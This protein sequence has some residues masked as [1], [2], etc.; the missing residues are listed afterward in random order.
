MVD[1]AMDHGDLST[2]SGILERRGRFGH[3]EHLELAWSFLASYPLEDA[4][5]RTVSMIRHV[6]TLH[7]A[8]DRYHDT[9]TKA[10]VRLVAVHMSGDRRNSFDDFI[11][12]NEGLL[13]PGLLER[14]YSSNALRSHAARKRWI[15]PDVRRLPALA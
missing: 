15:E 13:D 10:W 2:L 1:A 9:I 5:R 8:S 4:T 11:A 6:A 3:S 12:E 7:G 14:H